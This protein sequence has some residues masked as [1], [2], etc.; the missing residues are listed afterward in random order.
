[1]AA[2][3]NILTIATLVLTSAVVSSL[4][5][6]GWQAYARYLDRRLEDKKAGHIYLEL[7]LQLE[8][9]AGKCNERIYD[10]DEALG[11]HRDHDPNAFNNIQPVHLRFSPE[12]NWTSLPVAFVSQIKGLQN[13][14]TQSYAWIA[15]QFQLWAG[16]DDTYEFEQERMAFYALEACKVA[17]N[18][19]KKIKAGSGETRTLE[20]HFNLV[21]GKRRSLYLENSERHTFF[22]ELREKF[23]SEP[24]H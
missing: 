17:S 14:Y 8:E 18:L 13:R 7:A 1:M 12:P 19:R 6:V 4:V 24:R 15:A 23:E 11:R 22:P 16:M 5:N 20:N 10:I 9:F 21:I 3:L 2:E